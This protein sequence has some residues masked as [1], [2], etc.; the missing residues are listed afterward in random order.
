MEPYS[1]IQ[2]N[3][4]DEQIKWIY[5]W[6]S[7]RRNI[8]QKNAEET[9]WAY[10]KYAPKINTEDVRDSG[11]DV[12]K[13]VNLY[14]P[15][16]S[17]PTRNRV[18]KLIYSQVENAYNTPEAIVGRGTSD[19]YDLKGVYVDPNYFNNSGNYI[20]YAG[21]PKPHVRIHE[22]THASHPEQQENY[23]K[24][25]IFGGSVPN[26]VKPLASQLRDNNKHQAREIYGALQEFRYKNKLN[27]KQKIDKK[28][29]KNNRN[30]FENNYL[31]NLSDDVLLR[32]FNEVALND[33]TNPLII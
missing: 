8:L 17:N 13:F 20:A 7:Q 5:N 6:L 4:D 26:V 28:Y 29:L 15:F 21:N 27:P 11:W 16:V 24:D 19:N 12:E 25:I 14:N 23:I 18:N 9:D 3:K 32:L 10:S 33:N 31:K 22:L 2:K 30:L 1:K